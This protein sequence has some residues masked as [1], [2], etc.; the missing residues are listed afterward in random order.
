MEAALYGFVKFYLMIPSLIFD[1]VYAMGPVVA[2]I[3]GL[4]LCVAF[5]F[6]ALRDKPDA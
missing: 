2:P 3:L 4:A 6:I 5:P 1:A